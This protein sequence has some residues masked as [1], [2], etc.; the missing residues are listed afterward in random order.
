LTAELIV[1]FRR[2]ALRAEFSEIQIRAD[3]RKVFVIRW[4]VA[5]N[6]RVVTYEPRDWERT[7]LGWPEP[8]PLD[9][10]FSRSRSPRRP[11]TA[12]NQPPNRR[13]IADRVA[14]QDRPYVPVPVCPNSNIGALLQT[15]TKC[16]QCRRITHLGR[17][18][19]H[20]ARFDQIREPS[21]AEIATR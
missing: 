11:H 16:R 21:S 8:I 3:G 15:V 18:G 6:F 10:V 20:F 1:P 4:D 9:L 19:H 2:H 17:S 7:L 13:A 14:T 5:R 12:A